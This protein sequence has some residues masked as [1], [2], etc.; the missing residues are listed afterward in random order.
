MRVAYLIAGAGGMYCGSCMRDNRLAATLIE[1]GKDVTLIPLYTPIRTDERDVSEKEIFYGGI[2]VFLQQ[3]TGLFRHTPRV[4]DRMLDAPVLLRGVG[5]FAAKTRA[6]DLGALTVSVL[7][8]KDGRQRK[9][10]TRLVAGLRQLGPRVVVLPNLMFLGVAEAIRSEL[11]AAVVC[12]MS[13]ED[14]F[15]DALP[16]KFRDQSFDLIRRHARRVHGFLAPT[17]YYADR[18]IERLAL[19]PDVVHHTPM[20]IHTGD[21]VRD[22]EPPGPMTIGYLARICPEKGLETLVRAFIR[23]RKAG[24]DCRLRVAGFLGVA[25]TAYF[26]GVRALVRDAGLEDR[27]DFV[28][29]VD[30]AGKRAFLDTLHLLCVPTVYPEAKG[31]YLLEAMDA[32]VPVVQPRAGSF[33][34]LIEA[35]GGGVLFEPN[36]PESLADALA[37]LMDSDEDRVAMG[38]RGQAR[39]RELHTAGVMARQTWSVLEACGTGFQPV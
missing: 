12:A 1:M 24:R 28:G 3:K 22:V 4:I 6:E 37:D 10:L 33:P 25:D 31:L 38:R 8:G 16:Q 11:G 5:R 39:V 21:T 36:T 19:D 35:T 15:L 13:G 17:R 18:M 32:G 23:L 26:G 9:E 2:N 34:E 14:V 27:V 20:G 29:E 30:R 7:R